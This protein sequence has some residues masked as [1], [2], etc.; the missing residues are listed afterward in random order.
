[1]LDIRAI[2]ELAQR[3]AALVPPDLA[4]ANDDLSKTFKAALQAGLSRLDL[5]SREEF[6]VQ[7]LVLLRTREKVEVLERQIAALEAALAHTSARRT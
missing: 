4:A 3:L 1:M 7:R 5:V 2:D 6:D